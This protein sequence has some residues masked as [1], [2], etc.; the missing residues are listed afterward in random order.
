MTDT[1][2][3]HEFRTSLTLNIFLKL[4][5]IDKRHNEGDKGSGRENNTDNIKTN[6]SKI[7]PTANFEGAD[8]ETEHK[9]HERL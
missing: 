9:S 8:K 7:E 6:E 5:P 4:A 2:W 1:F 3:N